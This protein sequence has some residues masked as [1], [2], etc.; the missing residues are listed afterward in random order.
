M[1]K[2]ARRDTHYLLYIYDR[3]K[4]DIVEKSKEQPQVSNEGQD[5]LEKVLADIWQKSKEIALSIYAKPQKLNRS[6]YTLL[7][8]QRP[9][10]SDFKVEVFKRLWDWRENKAR[11]EDESTAYVM[12]NS[13]LCKIAMNPPSKEA[14]FD[15]YARTLPPNVLR[16]RREI[17]SLVNIIK[18]ELEQLGAASDEKDLKKAVGNEHLGLGSAH[19]NP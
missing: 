5:S 18:G 13:L 15:K 3:L 17:I 11:L 12:S 6:Y 14:D 9:L 1:I 2:Y 7:Q 8:N 16:A 4:I 10:M 19:A